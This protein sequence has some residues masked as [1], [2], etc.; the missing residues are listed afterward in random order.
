MI[1]C[2]SNGKDKTIQLIVGLIKKTLNEIPSSKMSQYLPKPFRRF[3]ENVNVKA[4]VSS[5]ATKTDLK[6]VR[7]FDTYFK[8]RSKKMSQLIN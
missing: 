8:F 7:H 4:D 6:N 1:N 2:M 3:G 5:Y